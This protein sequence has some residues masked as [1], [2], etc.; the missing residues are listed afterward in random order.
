MLCL[1][2]KFGLIKE[3]H[4]LVE[5][6]LFLAPVLLELLLQLEFLQD[7]SH[8]VRGEHWIRESKGR[9]MPGNNHL[10]NGSAGKPFGGLCDL[11]YHLSGHA[12]HSNQFLPRIQ[13]ARVFVEELK[14]LTGGLRGCAVLH[15][16]VE[17]HCASLVD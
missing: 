4:L 6:S 14:L 9:V 12:L 10:G 3:K 17:E 15:E 2:L 11:L 8:K 1:C 7:L 16:V 5:S 13:T